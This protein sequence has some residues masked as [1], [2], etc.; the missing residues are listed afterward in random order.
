MNQHSAPYIK[1]L[2]NFD[3]YLQVMAKTFVNE[4][5]HHTLKIYPR[6]CEEET[7]ITNSRTAAEATDGFKGTATLIASE[8][9]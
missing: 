2:I 9:E 5:D 3:Y 8:F 4:Y 1:E 7:Q 6:H